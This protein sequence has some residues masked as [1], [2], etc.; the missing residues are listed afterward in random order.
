MT[1]DTIE[2][3]I[4]QH[5]A[6][7]GHHDGGLLHSVKNAVEAVVGT[8]KQKSNPFVEQYATLFAHGARTPVLRRPDEYG[9]KYE[10]VFFPSLDG[11]K[12][13][14]WY[15]PAPGSDKLLIINHPM[16]CNRYGFPGHIAPWNSM[17]G[18]FEVNF[19]P[20]LRHLHDAGYN[21]L[22]YD[23]RNHGLSDSANG[24][25]AGLGLLECR[26]VVGSVRY[27]KSRPDTANMTVG[28][29]S[30]CMGGNSTV[31]AMDYWPEEFK[32][33]KTLVLLNVVSGKTFIER[34]AENFGMDVE[35]TVAE[36]DERLRELT[37]FH[38]DEET[39]R[40]HAHA[41]KVPTMMAQLRRDFLI[42][43]EKDGQEIFD[44]LGASDKEL[45]WIEESNQR[46]YAYNH[47][48]AHPEKL[49]DWLAKH[50]G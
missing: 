14:G 24:N 28:L 11:T 45:Y 43:G 47:F 1:T 10:D 6:D 39:P 8:V 32:D 4:G 7:I 29:Y 18:G 26:D 20:E 22:T 3:N 44:A 49:L 27:A 12:L 42:H 41:V 2:Q 21:I 23:L 48:G 9:M 50:M 30:R 40:P 37:G 35:K 33:I 36:M 19:L 5:D 38:L 46:F 34:G 16:P 15:I 13:E 17:F 31:I 25:I